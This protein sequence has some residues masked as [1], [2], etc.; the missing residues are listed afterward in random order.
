MGA[1]TAPASPRLRGT[2]AKQDAEHH[3]LTPG[4]ED[5]DEDDASFLLDLRSGYSREQRMRAL[6]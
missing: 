6:E 3:R 5:A 1:A 4:L 2:A